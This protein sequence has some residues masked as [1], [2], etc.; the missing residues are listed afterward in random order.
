MSDMRRREFISLLGGAAA[1]WPLAARAQQQPVRPLIGIL[2]PL[3]A[4]SAARNI[5]AFRSG[6]RDLGY[7]EGRNATLEIRYGD[8]AP[9]RMAPLAQELVAIKPDV[10]IAG[11]ASGAFALAVHAATRT[12]PIV[13][14]TPEDPVAL[15]LAHS[16]TK[17]GSNITGTWFDHGSLVGKRLEFLKL[18]VPGL[19]RVGVV[20]NPD[21]P[22]DAHTIPR[23]P[24]ATRALGV[25][26]EQ[27]EVRDVTKFDA[28]AA[29]IGRA[30]VEALLVGDGPTLNSARADIIVIVARL[31]LPAMYGF[32][33]FADAGGLMSYGYNL[34]DAYRQTARLVV[35][36]L[37][38]D[39]PGDLPFEL[40]ARHELIVNLKAAK[41]IGLTIPDSFV[42]L[43][44]EVIE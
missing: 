23:L 15:G 34:P 4:A 31:R 21:D 43:A 20:V 33:E 22:N 10:L 25:T 17:P 1:A 30:G 36:I 44:D 37:K 24:A 13:V 8:G 5:A 14:I 40:P 35:K 11:G 7:L 19:A 27:F 18:A 39:R 9:E 26:V 2:S 28:V 41:A 32:R 3:S 42:L 38:G 12:I 29:A 16:I 6:L